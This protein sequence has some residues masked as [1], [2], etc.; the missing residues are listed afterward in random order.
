MSQDRRE[1]LANRLLAENIYLVDYV[2]GSAGLLALLPLLY[3]AFTWVV[4]DDLWSGSEIYGTALTVPGSPQ[5]WGTVFI[6][7]GASMLYTALRQT[8]RWVRVIAVLTAW[9]LG[10]F[11]I[12]FGLEYVL[13]SNESCLP[14][15][16]GW[17][18]F[19]LLYMNLWRYAN[20]MYHLRTEYQRQLAELDDQDTR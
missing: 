2:R 14:P 20:K 8:Y 11:M 7:L 9:V 12:T 5:S 19:A 6:L 3:G 15:A 18:V 1:V 10:M 4:G 16:L 13:H 17:G